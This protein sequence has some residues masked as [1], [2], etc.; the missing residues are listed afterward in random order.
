MESQPKAIVS[1]R[2]TRSSK[3][4][5]LKLTV[6]NGS[7]A[8]VPPTPS[9]AFRSSPTPISQPKVEE[10]SLP[11]PPPPEKS[12]RRQQH[13]S[14]MSSTSSVER[15]PRKDSLESQTSEA[16][17]AVK[18]KP[19][20]KFTSLAQLGNGP[21]GGKGGPLPPV[22][23]SRKQSFDDEK[24]QAS[25][26]RSASA[27][28]ARKQSLSDGIEY[29]S[30]HRS[31]SAIETRVADDGAS[32]GQSPKLLPDSRPVPPAKSPIKEEMAPRIVAP[33]VNQLPPTPDENP[34]PPPRKKPFTGMGLP[35]NP[36]AKA[37]QHSRG[38]SSTGFN[39]MKSTKVV[40]EPQAPAPET[41]TPAPTPSPSKTEEVG[42]TQVASSVS[43]MQNNDERRP[44]SFEAAPPP[45]PPMK[46]IEI[47]PTQAP[48]QP[49]SPVS[50]IESH[51]AT[52]SFPPRS[53]SRPPPAFASLPSQERQQ[54][55]QQSSA[56]PLASSYRPPP[57]F[58]NLPS[59]QSRQQQRDSVP[60]MPPQIPVSQQRPSTPPTNTVPATEAPAPKTPLPFAPLTIQPINRPTPPLTTK[61]LT[62]YSHHSTYIWSRNTFQPMACM[63]CKVNDRERKWSCVWCYLRVC[64]ACSA[65]LMKTPQ[66]DLKG[67]ID[68]RG[69]DVEIQ[70]EDGNGVSK[71]KVSK[72]Q[73]KRHDSGTGGSVGTPTV[74][75][76]GAEEELDFS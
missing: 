4:P 57:A 65:E 67:L 75:V 32:T 48:V 2:L 69:V 9:L 58:A 74:V 22:P 49:S 71:E 59:Q 70:G 68:K 8:I 45:Q 26:G 14:S 64:V 30:N 21:R 12:K 20:P 17:G 63:V 19:V 42:Q 36:R 53:T 24:E 1:K 18:R 38:K 34:A 35:S 6:S 72:E 41:I 28:E 62:C 7:T 33:L 31:L 54:Q 15:P 43:P 13:E 60:T 44:F 52:Q 66:R 46:D 29:A 37:Q 51:N 10:K 40:P 39:F 50:P 61:H 3:P 56:P 76:W 47:M 27:V 73:V 23:R 55:Q 25:K 16:A 5:S 11:P